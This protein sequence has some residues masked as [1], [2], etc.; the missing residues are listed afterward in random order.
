[1][2]PE[3][4][5]C[6][7]ESLAR[8]I[9][10]SVV[11]LL[12]VVA[13]LPQYVSI[14]CADKVTGISS[15]YVL[16]HA[17]FSMTSLGFRVNQNY[18]LIFG[19]FGCGDDEEHPEGQSV[20][21]LM[22]TIQAAVQCAC[23]LVLLLLFAE[24]QRRARVLLTNG[25]LQL[26]EAPDQT[27]SE[28]RLGLENVSHRAAYI[29]TA[30]CALVVTLVSLPVNMYHLEKGWL[31][32]MGQLYATCWGL[33]LALL[34]YLFAL[35]QSNSQIQ[36]LTS[37]RAKGTLSLP[38]AVLLTV[39]FTALG[40]CQFLHSRAHF[41]LQVGSS[42]TPVLLIFVYANLTVP[43]GYLLV[44]VGNLSVVIL[45]IRYERK[46]RQNLEDVQDHS[47]SLT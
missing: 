2:G 28:E 34:N 17:L 14:C 47:E 31:I 38:S 36:L 26:G 11:C 8:A 37:T 13:Y 45:C 7:P 3:I 27:T 10:E 44:A 21:F 41:K 46:E 35:C 12:I 24:R 29:I 18:F 5:Q 39:A 23:A 43:I 16:L 42:P 15:V 19:A 1:M 20:V 22:G 40:V 30:S 25:E 33:L 6:E 9:V 4:R 32:H